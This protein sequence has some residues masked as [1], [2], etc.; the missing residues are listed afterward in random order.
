VASRTSEQ[1]S[2][3]VPLIIVA[4]TLPVARRGD[5]VREQACCGTA[6]RSNS[7]SAEAKA[8]VQNLKA[9]AGWR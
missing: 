3:N 4:A 9:E 1:R 5:L 8:Y 2:V 6:A 7:A